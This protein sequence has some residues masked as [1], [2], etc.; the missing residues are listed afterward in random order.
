MT[1]A[2]SPKPSMSGAS[3]RYVPASAPMVRS[4]PSS[5]LAAELTAVQQHDRVA[6]AGLQVTGDQPVDADFLAVEAH[7]IAIGLTGAPTAPIDLSGG[8]TSWNS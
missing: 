5:A 8:A 7:L 6:R 4:Q 1:F 2:D 3:T